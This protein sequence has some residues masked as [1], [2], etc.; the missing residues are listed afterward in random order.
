MNQ[1]RSEECPI[2]YRSYSYALVP[3]SIICGHSFCTECCKNLLKCPICRTKIS[4]R[5]PKVT[6]YSLLSL[7]NRLDQSEIKEMKDQEVQTEKPPKPPK[8][9]IPPGTII[10]PPPMAL[11]AILKL[12]R[13]QQLLAKTFSANSNS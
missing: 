13:I 6:N 7:V 2:C 11:S 8:P 4:S 10:L 5:T 3:V 12:T 9:T 1:D